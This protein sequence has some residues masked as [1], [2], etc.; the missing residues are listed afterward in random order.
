MGLTMKMGERELLFRFT[1]RAWLEIEEKIGSLTKLLN[2]I[3]EEDRP[4]D[5][6]ITLAAACATAG[7]RYRGSSDVIT[8]DMLIDGLSPKEIKRA[9]MMARRALTLGMRREEADKDDEEIVDVVLEEL[10]R[11]ELKKKDTAQGPD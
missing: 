10:R 4:L 11:E 3:D 9:N 5:A 7:E 8:A 2:R 1:T 6:S